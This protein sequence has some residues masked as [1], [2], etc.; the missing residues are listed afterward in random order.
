MNTT[1]FLYIA[2]AICPDRPFIIFEGR[3]WSFAQFQ[4]R[5]V[6][7]ANAL[8]GLGV[9]KGDRI[10][11]LHVNCPQYVEAYF[12]AAK[13]GAIFVPINFRAKADEL[14]YMIGNAETQGLLAGL[15]TLT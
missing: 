9:Q 4:E 5:A 13:I 3:S 12:A 15:S 11:M 1:E 2:T 7:L 14:A 6:R 10:G 8:K